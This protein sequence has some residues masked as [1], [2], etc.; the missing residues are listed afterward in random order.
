MVEQAMASV[1]AG[2]DGGRTIK[3]N[4][5][6]VSVTLPDDDTTLLVQYGRVLV[7]ETGQVVDLLDPRVQVDERATL[8]CRGLRLFADG[9]VETGQYGVV[10]SG[11]IPSG[12]ELLPAPEADFNRI[13]KLIGRT[14]RGDRIG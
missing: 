7:A 5:G 4:G 11:R 9:S 10:L 3:L 13:I 14:H 2:E 6:W 1:I 8:F 12:R